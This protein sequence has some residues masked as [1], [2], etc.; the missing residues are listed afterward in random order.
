MS[1][2]SDKSSTIDFPPAASGFKEVGR[3]FHGEIAQRIIVTELS[4][5]VLIEQSKLRNFWSA[6]YDEAARL[7]GALPLTT[8][9]F[10]FANGHLQNALE[11]CLNAEFGAAAFELRMVRGCVQRL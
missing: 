2:L 3:G 6:G 5:Q 1:D 7:I 8:A 9:E 11:Y 10:L 4:I